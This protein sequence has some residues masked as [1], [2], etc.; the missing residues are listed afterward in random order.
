VLDN[1]NTQKIASLYE[2]F[3]PAEARRIARKLECNYP[4]RLRAPMTS[5]FTA[6]LG[7]G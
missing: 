6:C 2:A 1:L 7:K 5:V 3:E 4:G